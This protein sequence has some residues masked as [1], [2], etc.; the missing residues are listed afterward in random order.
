MGVVACTG[1]FAARERMIEK[2]MK[3]AREGKF[4]SA[5]SSVPG[6]VVWG[7]P[8]GRPSHKSQSASHEMVAVQ[9]HRA[10]QGPVCER[11]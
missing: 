8:C 11:L 6:G 5:S 4:L 9:M 7:M 3:P 1:F 10:N 2:Q